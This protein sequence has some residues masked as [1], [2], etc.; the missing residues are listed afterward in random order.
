LVP[1]TQAAGVLAAQNAQDVKLLQRQVVRRQPLRADP[2]EPTGGAMKGHGQPV[3]GV[4]ER[5]LPG[6]VF[7]LH[8]RKQSLKEASN[9]TERAYT[10]INI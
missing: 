7:G 9:D 1:A 8:A 10:C 3:R 4:F 6:V 2:I 5:R